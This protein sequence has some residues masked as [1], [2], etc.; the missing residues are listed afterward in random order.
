M[1]LGGREGT[2]LPTHGE[3]GPALPRTVSPKNSGP[4]AHP[5]QSYPLGNQFPSSL[6]PLS[7]ASS[8]PGPRGKSWRPPPERKHLL[9]WLPVLHPAMRPIWR[10]DYRRDTTPGPLSL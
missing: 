3:E 8:S 4:S 6:P 1:R 9:P 7:P 10:G 2:E 5:N